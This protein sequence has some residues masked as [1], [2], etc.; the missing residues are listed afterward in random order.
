MG[1]ALGGVATAFGAA[2]VARAATNLPVKR[3]VGIGAG[4]RAIQIQK[5]IH[6]AA[7]V[8][9]VWDLWSNFENFP[10]FMSH[11]REV[12]KT[13]E[14][15][16]WTAVGPAGIPVEWDA[17]TTEW[18]PR[19]AIGWKSVEGSAIGNAGRV[20]FRPGPDGTTDIDIRLSYNPPAGAIGH[21]VAT[22]LGSNPKQALEE[23]L[24]RLKSLLEEGKTS[25]REGQV[26]LEELPGAPGT[27]APW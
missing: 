4:R 14:R 17:E 3:L 25:A 6:V 11:L 12:R 1:G 19:Q 16:H 10:R 18:E 24:L 8:E 2:L 20:R 15:S 26:R 23:D 7:P 22:L 21:G 5:T 27:K 9:S 13:G